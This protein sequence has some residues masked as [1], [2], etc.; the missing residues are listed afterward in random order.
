MDGWTPSMA[1]QW[2]R[3]RMRGE[4]V[5]DV[6]RLRRE[7]SSTGEAHIPRH[8][9]E[10]RI[11]H[12]LKVYLL[13]V[14][15]EERLTR[16]QARLAIPQRSRRFVSVKRFEVEDSEGLRHVLD[17][18]GGAIGGAHEAQGFDNDLSDAELGILG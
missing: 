13:V 9:G 14:N 5:N 17:G 6:S 12:L 16:A 15:I 10:R 3:E 4:S 18:E 11:D 1:S 2:A 7:V 8:L